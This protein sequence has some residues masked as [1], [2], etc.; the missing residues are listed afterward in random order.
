MDRHKYTHLWE[1][2]EAAAEGIPCSQEL[3][4]EMILFF[5]MW[6]N[7]G[8]SLSE[9]RTLHVLPPSQQWDGGLR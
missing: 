8:L 6:E 7:S 3:D 1:Q 4:Y 2:R 5:L 9:G